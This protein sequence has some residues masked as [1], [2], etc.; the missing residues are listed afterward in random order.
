MPD[1]NPEM[2]TPRPKGPAIASGSNHVS[3]SDSG[4]KLPEPVMKRETRR[5]PFTVPDSKSIIAHSEN[6]RKARKEEMRK[7]LALPIDEKTT[8][9]ARMVAMLRQELGEQEEEEEEKKNLTPVKSRTGLLQQTT[10]RYKLKRAMMKRN[11]IPKESKHDL[12]SLERQKAVLEKSVTSKMSKIKEMDDA[13]MKEEE[14]QRRLQKLLE[15]DS[16]HLKKFL[17]ENEKKSVEARAFFEREAKLKQEKTAAIQKLTSEIGAVTSEIAKQEEILIDYTRYKDLLFELS[18]PEWKEAQ[19]AKALKV[20][21][22]ENKDLQSEVSSPGREL[23][24]SRGAGLSTACRDTLSRNPELDRDN[25]EY[26]DEP[27][28]YFTDPQQLL[29]LVAD[30]TDKSLSLIQNTTRV[31]ETAEGLRHTM[32]ETRQE[33]ENED[34]HLTLQIEDISRRINEE[35]VRGNKLKQLVDLHVLLKKED[36]DVMLGAL[37]EKVAEVHR[38]C[39]DDRIT[40]LSTLEKLANIE[41]RVVTLLQDLENVDEESLE[42]MK[43]IKD[44]E[45]RKSEREEKLRQQKEKQKEMKKRYLERAMADSKKISG[46]KLMPR[47]KPF[48]QKVK[49]RNVDNTQAEDEMHS[50]LFTPDDDE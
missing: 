4:A 35:K 17:R 9:D 3:E 8:P 11:Q 44:S 21:S 24:S 46:R 18:P 37:G 47:C 31:E 14:H 13:I 41:R 42:R 32:E 38:C 28:I 25:S 40:N 27:E 33:I 12:L 6:E 26:E 43:K 5:S 50:Y 10:I 20:P 1:V 19:K 34:E 36:Q 48:A 16:L 7:F 15:L 22:A 49:V 23:P 29:D 39:V 45:K 30:L 2:S